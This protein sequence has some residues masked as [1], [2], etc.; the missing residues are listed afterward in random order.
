[1]ESSTPCYSPTRFPAP[2]VRT[3]RAGDFLLSETHYPG[4][5]VLPTHA[6]EYACVVVVLQGSFHAR[7]GAQA[8][9]AAPGTVIIRSAG[10]P[11]SN[12]FSHDG[13]RC[14]NVELSP[15]WLGGMLDIAS[16]STAS[17][18]GSCS[19]HGRRLHL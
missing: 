4:E 19:L 11:H 8:R 3:R 9:T 14:L 17:S 1:M 15:Q 10:E 2:V 18:G 16:R 6:H 13:G 7:Q 5:A 12:H